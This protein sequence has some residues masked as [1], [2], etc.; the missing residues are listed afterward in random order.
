MVC[1]FGSYPS[2]KEYGDDVLV[3][4]VGT[5]KMTPYG[6]Q[7]T[8]RLAS[9]LAK[10]GVTIV[11]G[12]ATGIDGVA[13]R[14][15]LDA[16]GRTIAVLGNPLDRIYPSQH[17]E[18]AREILASGGA[19]ISELAVGEQVQRWHFPLRNRLI[20]ALSRLVIVTESG[21]TGGSLITAHLA[22]DLGRGIMAVPGNITSQSS[23][24][25]NQLIHAGAT[26]IFSVT[27]VWN[28]L[29]YH[30]ESA[31]PVP[32]KSREEALL[33][34]L[35]KQGEATNEQLIAASG[36]SAAEVANHISLMEITG[37]IRNLGAG[38]WVLR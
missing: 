35:I 17:R 19:L 3:A 22:R 14:A 7:V 6:E 2:Q 18:L 25:T 12:L 24:G 29:G 13:H 26:P 32:A 4:I 33:M 28:E 27:D 8:Y 36:M 38:T 11:S 10:A 1:W 31:R 37:K 20:V 16:G 30:V 23:A 15:A 9:E 21:S 5:R 34:D